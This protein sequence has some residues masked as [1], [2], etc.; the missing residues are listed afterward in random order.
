VLA[1]PAADDAV[2]E[3]VLV[4]LDVRD[5]VLVFHAEAA[6]F[7]SATTLRTV[8]E[9]AWTLSELNADY[10]RF[11]AS[12]SALRDTAETMSQLSPLDA[13]ALR[14]LLIHDYRRILLKDPQLPRDLLPDV[15]AGSAARDLCAHVYSAI[16]ERADA[17]VAELMETFSGE[18]PAL[19][20]SYHARFGGMR[21]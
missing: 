6:H 3:K 19:A 11:I 20:L 18:I 17:H 1:H 13:F 12:F 4:G 16:A 15:W 10:E 21:R 7:V 14:T 8:A 2:V 5:A 9:D